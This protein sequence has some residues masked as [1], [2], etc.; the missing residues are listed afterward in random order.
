MIVCN[1]ELK[2]P[3]LPEIKQYY[4]LNRCA[5][6]MHQEIQNHGM[7]KYCL[8]QSF[9]HTIVD[10]FESENARYLASIPQELR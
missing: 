7:A 2:T 5:K 4:D 6:L 1:I 3:Y 10:L 8:V 9:N